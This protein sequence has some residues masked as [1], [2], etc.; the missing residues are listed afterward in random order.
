MKLPT[1]DPLNLHVYGGLAVAALGG[2]FLHWAV[3]L[4]VLGLILWG[5][6]VF[7]PPP[8]GIE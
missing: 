4:V 7:P 8:G 3:T 1:P 2:L 6:G 5:M